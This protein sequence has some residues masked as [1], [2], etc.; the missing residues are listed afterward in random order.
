MV[1]LIHIILSAENSEGDDF[2]T[3]YAKLVAK[4]FPLDVENTVPEYTGEKSLHWSESRMRH[5]VVQEVRP[6][7]NLL[8]PKQS[9]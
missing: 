7:R 1:H 9:D 3:V 6:K 2:G 8:A 5:L 4:S